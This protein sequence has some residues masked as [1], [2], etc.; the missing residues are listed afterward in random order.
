MIN[1][2]DFDSIVIVISFLANLFASVIDYLS[3]SLN[4]FLDSLGIV[5]DVPAWL[6]GDMTPLSLMLGVGLPLYLGHQFLKWV[7]NVL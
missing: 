6:G 2:S 3:M 5:F 4:D 1:V 7:T